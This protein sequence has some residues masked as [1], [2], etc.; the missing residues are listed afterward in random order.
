MKIR[1][2]KNIPMPFTGYRGKWMSL[3]HQMD[4]GDSF[5]VETANQAK[6]F[7][8]VCNRFGHSS[9]RRPEGKYLRVWKIKKVN[10]RKSHE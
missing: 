1:V 4:V 10:K 2:E 6:S 7:R 9:T 5:L 8:D 3:Y